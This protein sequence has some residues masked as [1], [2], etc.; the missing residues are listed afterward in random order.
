MF[1]VHIKSQLL[2]HENMERFNSIT[3]KLLWI[4]NRSK[5]DLDTSVYLLCTR[6]QEPMSEE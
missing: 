1:S 3:E 5:P 2:Y 4:M 6:V